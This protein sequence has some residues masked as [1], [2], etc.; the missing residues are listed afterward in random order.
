MFAGHYAPAILLGRSRTG[1]PL[2]LLFLAVQAV[3][4]AFMLLVFVG[5]E[6]GEL[7]ADENPRFLVTEGVWTHSL[8]LTVIYAVAIGV[9]GAR[10]GR[11]QE[12]L[13]LAAAVASHWVGDLIVHDPDLPLGFDQANAVGL[14]LWTRPVLAWMLEVGMVAAAGWFWVRRLAG[15]VRRR[16]LV[17]VVGLCALQTFSDFVSPLPSD[18]VALA[19]TTLPVPFV[20][21]MAARWV[22]RAASLVGASAG[23]GR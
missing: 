7:R 22:E 11:A 15:P 5:I 1:L 9:V 19:L 16:A 13:V 2:W 3:D 17:L 21:A 18:D 23:S 12:A 20:A 10:L 6:S 14:S 8:S 4:I